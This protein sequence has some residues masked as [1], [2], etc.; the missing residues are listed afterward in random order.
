MLSCNFSLLTTHNNL[1]STLSLPSHGL[2]TTTTRVQLALFFSQFSLCC[3]LF[4]SF[5]VFLPTTLP[6]FLIHQHLV[7]SQCLDLSISQHLSLLS[8]SA[9]CFTPPFSQLQMMVLFHR[10]TLC[11]V[12]SIVY[13]LTYQMYFDMD[14]PDIVVSSWMTP[15][16]V[17]N[18]YIYIYIYI[19]TLNPF[20][21][22]LC[23]YP[24]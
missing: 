16:M 24:C 7:C 4:N 6:L 1:S 12:V 23:K 11:E 10:S 14:P 15:V 8:I 19:Y 21:K 9:I 18:I 17:L 22:K 3:L 20:T 2:S 13:T 5:L